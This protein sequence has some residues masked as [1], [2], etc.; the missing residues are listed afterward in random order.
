MVI[1][2]LLYL[3]ENNSATTSDEFMKYKAAQSV[4]SCTHPP[5]AAAC[6]HVLPRLSGVSIWK[7]ADRT[8][9]LHIMLNLRPEGGGTG[10]RRE[11]RQHTSA[12]R[13]RKEEKQAGMERKTGVSVTGGGK[14][15]SR[16]H[17]GGQ[18]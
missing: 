1:F 16:D 12:E 13:R 11:A 4:N 18:I 15:G 3:S 6:R 2:F 17:T 7:P 10:R 8:E 9:S 14:R 5:A